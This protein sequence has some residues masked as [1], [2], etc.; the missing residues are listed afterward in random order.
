[1]RGAGI[2]NP[3]DLKFTPVNTAAFTV[4]AGVAGWVD[5]DVSATTGVNTR[6]V[7]L[8]VAQTNAQ[9]IGAR[10]HG[11]TETPSVTLWSD[12]SCTLMA[13][14]DAAGHIDFYRNAVVTNTYVFLGYLELL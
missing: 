12:D 3:G 7:W 13:M 6:R 2:I 1:M 4:V 9:A 5:T 11:R 10:E 14:V 8:I